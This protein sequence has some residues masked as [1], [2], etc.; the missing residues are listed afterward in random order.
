MRNLYFLIGFL[1][2]TIVMV[3]QEFEASLQIRPRF[4]F[5]NGYKTLLE[6][7]QDPAT[8]VSQR[9]RLNLGFLNENLQVKFSLQNIR[10][11][12]DV[13]LLTTSDKNGIG[14]FEAWGKYYVS[15][16]MGFKLGRQ[17]LSYNN[18]RILGEVDWAQ[19]GQSHDAALLQFFPSKNHTLDLGVAINSEKEELNKNAYQVN[20]YKN[21]QFGW[22]NIK[23]GSSEISFLL[24]N[25]GYETETS[26]TKREVQYMQ[27]WGSF[28][29]FSNNK[30]NGNI[31]AYGQSGEKNGSSLSA[32]YSGVNLN[33]KVT[34]TL[35]LGAGAEY[36]TGTD[37]GN[38]SEDLNSFTPLFGTNHGFNGYM[39]Y[40]YVGNHQNSVGLIDVF[41]KFSYSK[42]KF[43]F[44]IMPHFF[45]SEADIKDPESIT[46]DKYLG[47]EIDL[48]GTITLSKSA[49]VAFG[50]SQMFGTE[51]LK[52]LKGGDPNSVQNWAWISVNFQPN[53]FVLNLFN[54]N[55]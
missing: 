8:F 37:M 49:S 1:L 28:Y 36:L 24:L 41:T 2:C 48:A 22:Y 25:A 30:W 6:N 10:V 23:T 50:Y 7:E 42:G 9:T 5:R 44:T 14:V 45:A 40:F 4:E 18:Q 34:T 12:G 11:W 3:A 15:P 47:T 46:M 32:W 29:Q 16:T 27:T 54:P 51:S 19:Q 31:A 43:G 53:S 26:T 33:Y 35:R 13:P 17:V 20:N 38:T 21:M 55:N 39:D 52:R